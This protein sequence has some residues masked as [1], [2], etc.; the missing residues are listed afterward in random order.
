MQS[1]SPNQRVLAHLTSQNIYQ[2]AARA[3]EYIGMTNSCACITLQNN[4]R[5]DWDG[6]DCCAKTNNGSVNTK[7]CKVRRVHEVLSVLTAI[8]VGIITHHCCW[9]Q[10]CACL[11]PDHKNDPKCKGTCQTSS[12]KGDGHC[13]D[14]NK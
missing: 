7:Y 11:D 4:C 9:F 6:G 3:H 13:D 10:A 14:G 1:I 2:H 12:Y 5:C 8:F